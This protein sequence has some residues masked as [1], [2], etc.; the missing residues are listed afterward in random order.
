M[1]SKFASLAVTFTGIES[2]DWNVPEP[3]V[4]EAKD[5]AGLAVFLASS[6]AAM[7]TGVAINVDGGRSR[8][9]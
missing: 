6:S 4:G 7:I 2:D 8:S 1:P 5:I 9:I 3:R